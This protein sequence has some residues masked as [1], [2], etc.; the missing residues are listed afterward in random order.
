[1]PGNLLELLELSLF[2]MQVPPYWKYP[3]QQTARKG[4]VIKIKCACAEGQL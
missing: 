1:M 2:G 4:S 3:Q